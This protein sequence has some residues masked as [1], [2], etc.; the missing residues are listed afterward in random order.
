MGCPLNQKRSK[1]F[2]VKTI[3]RLPL[4]TMEKIKELDVFLVTNEELKE[5][6]EGIGGKTFISEIKK[7]SMCNL[8]ASN[9]FWNFIQR[10]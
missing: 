2:G 9:D 4:K 7:G 5:T 8:W 6:V 3:V 10:K 1:I